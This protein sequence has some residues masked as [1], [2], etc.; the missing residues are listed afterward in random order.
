[1]EVF[2]IVLLVCLSI[3]PMELVR[4]KMSQTPMLTPMALVRFKMSITPMLTPMKLVFRFVVKSLLEC[5]KLPM[6]SYWMGDVCLVSKCLKLL[7]NY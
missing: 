3:T 5:P 7:L 1:M 6:N 2:F 4:F